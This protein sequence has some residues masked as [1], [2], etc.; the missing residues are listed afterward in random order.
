YEQLCFFS[1]RY[2][3]DKDEAEDIIGE[4]FTKLWTKQLYQKD[5]AHLK[6]LLYRSA[7]HAC[8]D[9]IKTETNSRKRQWEFVQHTD[10]VSDDYAHNMIRAE[11][12]GELYQAIK[13]LPEQCGKVIVLS[14]IEE[15]KNAEIAQH[16][17][18][19]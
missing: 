9:R 13:K 6:A 12:W 17:G 10:E 5:E 14:Y 16:M 1:E 18:L 8:L 19:S 7:Y 3:K 15:K 11:V 4:L 2:L